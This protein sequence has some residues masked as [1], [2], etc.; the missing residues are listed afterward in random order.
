MGGW[1]C[2]EKEE[3]SGGSG[4]VPANSSEA[5]LRSPVGV[6]I[7]SDLVHHHLP[8]EYVVAGIAA[9][10]S[11]TVDKLVLETLDVIGTLVDNEQEPPH[12][13]LKLHHIADKEEG[14]IQVVCSMVI[15]YLRYKYC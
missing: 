9:I 7:E 3:T 8:S 4:E 13:M 12:S 6:G 2:K 14:W 5:P 10:E 11:Q 1:C 15:S